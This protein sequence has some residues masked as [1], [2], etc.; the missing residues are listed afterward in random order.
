LTRSNSDSPGVSAGLRLPDEEEFAEAASHPIAAQAL[1]MMR[2][3]PT[4]A[5]EV[6]AALGEPLEEVARHL[7][8]LRRNGL[9]SITAT[10]EVEGRSEPLYHGPFV[11]FL[12][13]EEWGELDPTERRFQLQQIV[14]LLMHDIDAAL[15]AQTLDAWP[16]FHLCRVPL[17]MDE[18]GWQEVRALFDEALLSSVRISEEAAERLRRS[19]EQGKRGTGGTVLFELPDAE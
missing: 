7:A 1:K 17:Q 6:A 12:D 8:D 16:D 14:N 5:S 15:E 3:R 18:Q 11:P 4:T 10:R 9:I 19:G 2:Q 13:K